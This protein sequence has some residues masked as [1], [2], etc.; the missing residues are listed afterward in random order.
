MSASF[1]V[2]AQRTN[3]S[4]YSYFG[5]GDEF[6]KRTVEQNAMGGIGVAFSHYKY[7]NFTN[8]AAYANLRYTTYSLAVLNKDLKVNTSTSS[9]SSTSTSLSYVALGFPIGKKAGFSLG[10][11]PLSSV[12]YSLIN[13][14]EDSNGD[15]TQLTSYEGNGGV[16]RLYG[17]FGISPLKNLSLGIEADFS[18]GNVNNQILSQRRDVSLATKYDEVT[19]I[20][21]GSVKLGLQYQKELKNKLVVNL[22][23]TVKL[24]NNLNLKGDEYLYSVAVSSG[25]ESPRDTLS[26]SIID[27]KLKLPLQ[28]NFGFGV[29]KTNKWYAG[30]EYETQEAFST[31]GDLV[32]Q[33]SAYRYDSSNR[34]SLGGFYLPKINS[35]SSYW[36][37]V[38]YRAG[39]RFE[40]TGLSIDGTGSNSNFT[41]IDDYGISFGV[42]LP[43]KGFST[44]KIG[45]ST[46][47]IGVEYG[48]R[49]TIENNLIQEKYLNVRISLSLTDTNWF[50]KRKID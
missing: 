28:A 21:G 35:I 2:N 26:A 16:N 31:S 12:G 17:A 18:F 40:K 30:F 38:T 5:V 23:S 15:L 1:I 45:F 24:E 47:N 22:G 9:Q 7:L 32:N 39:L 4:P 25:V 3:S 48:E 27:G 44:A 8:P 14:V 37:R 41:S 10:M 42:G 33:N 34:I 49:G 19:N 43:L 6:S 29:G 20:T 11:Q 50:V 46:A 13:S 36:H